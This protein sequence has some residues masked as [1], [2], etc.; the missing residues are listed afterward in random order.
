[1]IRPRDDSSRPQEEAQQ[2]EIIPNAKKRISV[3]DATV[4]PNQF[5]G[6]GES[7][8]TVPSVGDIIKSIF[9]HKW[10]VLVIFILVS[11]PALALVWTQIVP[12]YQAMAQVRVRPIIPYLVFK[13]EDSGAVPLYESYK[14][15]QCSYIKTDAVLQHVLDQPEIQQTKWW[16]NTP[17]SLVQRATKN[18]LARLDRLKQALS[19]RNL[20]GTEIIDITFIDPNSKDARLIVN[21]V[22]DQYLDYVVEMSDTTQDKLYKKLSDEFDSLKKEIDGEGR[23]HNASFT[24]LTSLQFEA[25]LI[26]HCWGK[27]TK[28]RRG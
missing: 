26:L 12:K 16:K 17:E 15:T 27:K 3:A 5:M 20:T 11:A 7:K 4:L 24:R 22:V 14:Q 8:Q 28:R 21:T 13:T 23:L 18:P 2:A 19:A 9:R 6:I 10:I 25:S 1:M